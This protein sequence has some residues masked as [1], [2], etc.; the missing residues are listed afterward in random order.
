MTNFRLASL[1]FAFGFTAA[2][3]AAE[4]PTVH[5]NRDIRP[6]LSDTCFHCHG[7]DA[8]TRKGG[9]RLD[10][11]EGATAA[12]A[13]GRAAIVPG[14]LEL[15]EFW[16]RVTSAD[17]AQK[18][19]PPDSHKV[20]KPAQVTKLK[21]WIEQGAQ[22]EKHWAFEPP[23]RPPVPTVKQAAWPQTDPDRFVLA[24]LEAQQLS[25]AHEAARETLL[26]R[27]SLDLTGLP[28]TP[29]EVDAFLADTNA[30]AYE[31]AVDRLLAS[32][33]YGEHMARYWLDAA[34]Y[35]DTHGLHL[36]NE[37]SM[38]PYRDWVVGA[39]NQN[40][41]FDQFTVWQLAGDLLPSPTREQLIASGFNR[42]NV[43]TSEGGAIDEE[44]H[45]RY[46]VDRVETTATVFM[47]LTMG[48]AV[49][50][51]HKLDPITQ[52]EFYQM[53]AL[54]NNL[55]EKAMDGNAPLPPPMMK[56]PSPDQ[57]KELKEIETRQAAAKEQIRAAAA[58]LDYTDPAS[59]TNAPK[60]QPADFV[61]IE[62]DW[63]SGANVAV[64]PGNQPHKFVQAAEGK[65][66]SGQR[67]IE[68]SGE[69][70]HQVFFNETTQPLTAGAGDRLFAYVF[71]DPARL[72]KSIM[73]QWHTATWDRRA[74]WGDPD[75]IPYGAKGTPEKLLLGPLPKAGEWVRLEVPAE[76]LGL[77]PGTKITGIAF[78]QFDGAAWWDK[79][80]LVTVNDPTL[81]TTRSLAAW[82]KSEKALGDKATLPGD[83]KPI[84]KKDSGKR[85]EAEQ[86]QLRDHFLAQVYAGA[87]ETLTA[88]R[89]E[90]RK[91]GEQ[92]AAL[93]KAI[94]GTMIS[95]E[96]EK[97]RP[98]WVLT[99]GQY[100][101]HGEPVVPGVPQIL[102]P[103]PQGEATNRLTFA[104]WL[105]DPRHPL[106]ARVT[107][108][109]FWQQFFG[110]GLV[111]T[112][113]DF[114]SK[115]EWP[116]NPE[117]LDWL[118]TEFVRTGW[119]VKALVRMLVTSAA[120]RQDSRVT[121]ELFARDPENRLLARGPR[122]RLDAEVLR[123]NALFTSGLLVEKRGGRGVRPYQP[124]GIWEAVGYTTSDTAKF[125]QDQGDALWRRS[126]YTFWKRTAPPPSLT[127]FDAPSREQC[128]VRRE[129]TNTPLQ[130]LVTMNDPQYFEAARHLGW[131]MLREG[132]ATDADRLRY[133]FRL[134]TARAPRE[135]EQAVLA[136]N[137]TAH[138]ARFAADVDAAKKAVAVG[139]SPVPGE[140]VP[141]DL[142]A[143][144]MVA[145]LLLNL[146]EVVTKN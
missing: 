43:T 1:A 37:R 22:Y 4:G 95:K 52:K 14:K 65:V 7:F 10:T 57:D 66:F 93:D 130:A 105:V 98:A 136:D 83:L 28:P 146:D 140:A 111:K 131:R 86:Q 42:C 45:V 129:R 46:A 96:L 62:D 33:R 60:P 85:T 8:N 69:G 115:G 17:P 127:T 104:K 40:L 53:F 41:P 29:A 55:A 133:G 67:A 21:A 9:L 145:N 109:R 118:A 82:L 78:T 91:L 108:N 139:D 103:L 34:R 79:A 71:L 58:K 2:L 120:Y 142:A 101:Q 18:M 63:P 73:L 72:P 59:L 35:G 64:N 80:G 90:S 24:A 38:W 106:T 5:F 100:D 68:R 39:F 102:P 88:L 84:L 51:D 30:G 15:S 128:R 144:T 47:G 48:C 26:R 126:L 125:K 76:K 132:G 36:D 119:D 143:Y 135:A 124:P 138:R 56:V 20:L 77:K 113:E 44:F 27:V 75:A 94:P 117:L 70:L 116:A 141:A 110:T 12:N 112:S 114:G 3:R 13:K 23:Q 19:P 74:N 81:D 87:G 31:R 6:I 121:P 134:V 123:D 92:R 11:F 99:R 61:W 32:P 89:S 54:F 137:L 97:P 49:C 25:P 107:V 122:L 50:H 16:K